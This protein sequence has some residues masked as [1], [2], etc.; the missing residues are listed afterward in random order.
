MLRE[1]AVPLPAQTAGERRHPGS[2][3]ASPVVGQAETEELVILEIA[4]V[5]SRGHIVVETYV[6]EK[7]S[8]DVAVDEEVERVFPASLGTLVIG[9]ALETGRVLGEVEVIFEP[10]V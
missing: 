5:G 8:L 6:P 7:R 9:K 1:G 10:Y 3:D 2:K 4:A